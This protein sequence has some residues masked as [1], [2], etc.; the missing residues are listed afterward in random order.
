MLSVEAY[1]LLLVAPL[2]LLQ[3]DGASPRQAAYQLLLLLALLASAETLS[4]DEQEVELEPMLP[5]SWPLPAELAAA[6][7]GKSRVF[8]WL[9]AAAV[10]VDTEPRLVYLLAAAVVGRKVPALLA[11][12]EQAVAA[13]VCSLQHMK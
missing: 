12:G 1:G 13:K 9:A 8:E 4:T 2:Y 6:L 3:E 10:F 11:D 5:K 7:A